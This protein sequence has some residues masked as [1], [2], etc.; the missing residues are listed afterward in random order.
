MGKSPP[1]SGL[2]TYEGPGEIL[3]NEDEDEED[4]DEGD[5]LDGGLAEEEV[6]PSVPKI[7]E[8]LSCSRQSCHSEGTKFENHYEW[9]K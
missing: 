8:M 6:G 9:N 2:C 3:E 7:S 1:V 4:E 5:G